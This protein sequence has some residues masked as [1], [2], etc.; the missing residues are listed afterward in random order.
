METQQPRTATRYRPLAEVAE[1]LTLDVET[2][3]GLIE[4]GELDAVN[5]S[6]GKHRRHWRV[7]DAALEEFC[8]RRSSKPPA[9]APRHRLRKSPPYQTVETVET[10]ETDG[11][12]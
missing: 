3:A 11:P 2:L 9:P 10:V 6:S 5:V 12:F 4:R 1:I 7:S 8:R